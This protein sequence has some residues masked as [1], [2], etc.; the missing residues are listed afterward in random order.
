M[1]D[2]KKQIRMTV[3]LD[4]EIH[5]R[6]QDVAAAEKRSLNAQIN[7]LLADALKRARIKRE[8]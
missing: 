5:E 4:Q 7:V 1:A 2:A 8:S 6:L 3:R